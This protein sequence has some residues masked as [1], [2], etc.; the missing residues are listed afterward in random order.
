MFNSRSLPIVCSKPHDCHIIGFSIPGGKLRL[1]KSADAKGRVEI[2][3]SV[4]FFNVL[5]LVF[6]TDAA[7]V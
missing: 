7:S 4:V 3:N 5:Y 6:K 2:R 1:P